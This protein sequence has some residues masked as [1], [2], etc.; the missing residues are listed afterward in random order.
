MNPKKITMIML[1]SAIVS[2]LLTV[3]AA[4]VLAFIAFMFHFTDGNINAGVVIINILA[5]FIGGFM[6][7]KGLKEKKY[8]WG[9]MLGALYFVFLLSCSCLFSPEN[10]GSAVAG[11]TS[12][13][14]C[15]G[16]GMLGGM[17]G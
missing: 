3:V 7:G 12:A 17:L 9:L 8:L 14:I 2:W 15:L 16:S 13:L 11:M 10:N 4:V 5:C 1:R 6:A